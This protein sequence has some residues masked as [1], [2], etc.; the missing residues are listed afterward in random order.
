LT[1]NPEAG[2]G[3]GTYTEGLQTSGFRNL[4]HL[5]SCEMGCAR[6]LPSKVCCC[7]LELGLQ[8]LV[9]CLTVLRLA[10]VICS[11]FYG[12]FLY[13]VLSIGILYIAADFLL[14]YSLFCKARD[15]KPVC[16]FTN[17]KVWV[18][19]WQMM[20]LLGMLGVGVALGWY[21]TFG[22]WAMLHEP[23]HFVVFLILAAILPI[24]LYTAFIILA[25]YN[26]LKEAYIDE[27]LG[28]AAEEDCDPGLTHGG[29]RISV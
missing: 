12:P 23:V 15:G 7:P 25:L 26:Y 17:Q 19:M 1:V 3:R 21:L 29:R 9:G 27:L 10:G 14:V 18:V 24:M 11:G 2:Q 4:Q 8:A 22:F 13:L 5:P 16:D 20:N 6:I 28:R